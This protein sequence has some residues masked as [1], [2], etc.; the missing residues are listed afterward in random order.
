MRASIPASTWCITGTSGSSNMIS[1][2]RPARTQKPSR[3]QSKIE[4]PELL[5]RPYLLTAD[6]HIQFEI[7]DYD[8]TRPLVIDPVLVYSTY[9]GSSF[10]DGAGAIAVDAAGNAYVGGYTTPPSTCSVGSA[11]NTVAFVTRINASGTAVVY[12]AY[13]GTG[14]SVSSIAL[15]S[16]DDA[17]VTG[18]TLSQNFPT[19]NAIKSTCPSCTVFHSPNVGNAFVTKFNATGSALV[20]STYLGGTNDATGSGIAVDTGGNIYVTGNTIATDF[21]TTPEA[22]QT[23]CGPVNIGLN[24][25]PECPGDAFVTK[26]S[27]SGSLVYSTYL[28]GTEPDYGYALLVDGSGDAFVTGSTEST[29]FPTLNA[30]QATRNGGTQNAFV[31]ELNPTG[32]ALVYSTYLG[33]GV[34]SGL[35]I[36]RDGSS[37]FYVMT[38]PSCTI[39]A[40]VQSS[41]FGPLGAAGNPDI[42]VAEFN[43]SGSLLQT[44]CIGGSSTNNAGGMAVDSPGNIYLVG[45]TASLDFPTL[46][47]I[48]PN[49][50]GQFDAF[51]TKIA[52]AENSLVTLSPDGIGFGNQ[53][54]NTPSAPQTMILSN[55]AT[56][57]LTI[58]Q[59]AITGADSGDFAQT[60]DCPLPP[61]SL[62]SGTSCSLTVTFTPRATGGRGAAVT[63]TDNAAHSP[64]TAPLS[65]YGT[66][67][68]VT[69]LP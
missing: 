68:A 66:M 18:H 30:F 7:P 12:T 45:A 14:S 58:S 52:M 64:Q 61:S 56:E 51:I 34:V 65:G 37:N 3:W 69:L 29:D 44:A 22:F 8:K 5:D 67:P 31:T 17:I 32:S 4:N 26:F 23:N 41:Q 43:P 27:P 33:S 11:C 35:G 40:G 2:L 57:P 1:W 24:G 36:A 28:G 50:G 25:I 21:P 53:L 47:P 46:N 48:Q 49:N 19:V 59:I 20:F 55:K 13:L 60:S 62:A 10:D 54:I 42:F 63:V 15:D 9:M 38:W 39:Y 16:S 6:N